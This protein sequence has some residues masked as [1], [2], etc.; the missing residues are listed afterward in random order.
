MVQRMKMLDAC[1][2]NRSNF[3]VNED[4]DSIPTAL[5]LL[6]IA[7]YS[8]TSLP[9]EQQTTCI[10]RELHGAMPSLPSL[11]LFC[12]LLVSFL[13][14]CYTWFTCGSPTT[15]SLT[16]TMSL[17]SPMKPLLVIGTRGSPL[18]LAQAYETKRLLAESF[19][20]LNGESAIEIKKIMTKV[21]GCTTC[22]SSVLRQLILSFH[23]IREIV[24]S[25]KR[26][27]KSAEKVFLRR[28]W[29]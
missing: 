18:A 20:E 27:P 3:L 7:V 22:A 13:S 26:C 19:P 8:V 4:S 6:C 2:V 5:R 24:Y 16:V 28:S 29:T 9:F 11:Y 21:N 17:S 14:I 1:C 10:D 23:G 15:R 25:T 12:T